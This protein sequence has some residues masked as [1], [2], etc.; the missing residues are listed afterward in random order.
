MPIGIPGELF[1]GGPGVSQGYVNRPELTQERFIPNPFSDS[2]ANKLYRTGDLARWRPDGQI[3]FLGRADQQVKIRGYR[4]ELDEIKECILTFPVIEEAVVVAMSDQKFLVAYVVTS[5]QDFAPLELKSF[6]QLKLPNYMVPASVVKLEQLPRLPNGKI[7]IA[8]LPTVNKNQVLHESYQ[9]PKNKTQ[10]KLVSIWESVLKQSPIGIQDNFFEIGGDSI[11]SIQ[12]LAKARKEGLVFK[13]TQL[14][15]HQTIFELS[16]VTEVAQGQQIDPKQFKSKFNSEEY[17]KLQSITIEEIY[18]LSEMQQALLFHHLHAAEDQGLL[19]LEF[20]LSGKIKPETLEMAWN[21]IASRHPILRTTIHWEALDHPVQTVHSKSQFNWKNSDLQHLNKPKIDQ[22][23]THFRQQAKEQKPDFATPSVSNFHLIQ[24]STDQYLFMWTCHHI[25]IDGW[26]GGIIFSEVLTIYERLEKGEDADQHILP[27]FGAFLGWEQSIGHNEAYW[28]RRFEDF[29]KATLFQ[30]IE[31]PYIE[32]HYQDVT[33]VL[34]PDLYQ[35]A[36]QFTKT[37]R[38]TLN[39]L[40]HGLWALLLSKYCDKLDIVFGATVSGRFSDFPDIDSMSGLFMNVIPNRIKVKENSLPKWLQA[41]QANLMES[42]TFERNSLI[43][44]KNSINWPNEKRLFD[45]L[46]VFG[47]FLVVPDDLSQIR[48]EGFNGGFTSTYPLTLRVTPKDTLSF[49]FRYESHSISKDTITWLIENIQVL[50]TEIV[51]S[52]ELTAIEAL[53]KI[54]APDFRT[55]GETR[56]LPEADQNTYKPPRNKIELE[57][58]KIW[59]EVFN[60]HPIGIQENF[61]E[62]GGRSIMALSVFSLIHERFGVQL[63]PVKL[64]SHPTIESLAQLLEKSDQQ[65][66]W[67]SL[68]S[69]RARGSKTPLICL[70][71]G[72][73]HVF[74]YRALTEYLGSDQPVYALEP[75]GLDGSR[76]FHTTVEQMAAH[77]IKEI[78]SVIPD[79]PYALL[80][81]CFSNTVCLE[82]AHQL[83][84]KGKAVALMVMIDSGPR[85]MVPMLSD[86]GPQKRNVLDRLKKTIRIWRKELQIKLSTAYADQIEKLQD[87]LT[88]LSLKY[89]AKVYTKGKITLIRSSEFNN[90]RDKDHHIERWSELAKG[91]LEVHVVPGHHISLFEEPEVEGLAK[92]LAEC[93]DLINQN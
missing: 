5:H 72:G 33:F 53:H 93:L 92:K 9:A 10:S 64:L 32:E 65:Q 13:P 20:S 50:F 66:N 54:S 30:P 47:N 59:E 79:G 57:L 21:I 73:G 26:S 22:K 91:G 19:L 49:D 75:V 37:H 90:R 85:R 39:T 84:S 17:P 1:I 29:H 70:H 76:P 3:E 6:L 71:A 4:V 69:L 56:K 74:F 11:L 51:N 14:F 27:A 61:F 8:A 87:V 16:Q 40:I 88:V 35:Q 83:E 41:I 62:I 2:S 38:I 36:I 67:E 80:G 42:R 44:I 18:P 81:T 55:S 12:V 46:I 82:M 34:D 15:D 25:L 68:V 48:I 43:D 31:T 7:N 58:A 23:I 78:E 24:V 86:K 63:A 52:Q 89:K 28:K 60:R 45:S 77:Y